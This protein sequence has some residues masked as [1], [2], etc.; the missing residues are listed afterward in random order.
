MFSR[1][2][3]PIRLRLPNVR[4]MTSRFKTSASRT[5]SS[6]AINQRKPQVSIV[7]PKSKPMVR[8]VAKTPYNRPS[9]FTSKSFRITRPTITRPRTYTPI[10]TRYSRPGIDY[11]ARYR[12]EQSR[13]RNL[14]T[15]INA[16]NQQVAQQKSK[17]AKEQA[18]WAQEKQ[19]YTSSPL[20]PVDRVARDMTKRYAKASKVITPSVNGIGSLGSV[21]ETASKVGAGLLGILFVAMIIGR[22][23]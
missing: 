20:Y 13:A 19:Q 9:I 22:V 17:H 3:G 14:Q 21:E 4:R 16:L 7:A 12:S 23:E 10:L 18:K 2:R 6:R 11:Q 15:R 5:L 1:R 8:P